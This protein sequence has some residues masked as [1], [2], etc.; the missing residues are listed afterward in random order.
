MKLQVL[1][2]AG[3]IGGHQ[4]F[5]TCLQVDDDIL[6]DAGT[7]ITSLDIDQLVKIDHV[8]ITHAHL[9]HVCGLALLVDAVRGKKEGPVTVHASEQVI[10]ALK[11][12]LFNWILWPDFAAI[13]SVENPVVRWKPF[14]PATAIPVGTRTIRPYPVNHT[15]GSV[16]Y[17]LEQGDAGFLFSGDMGTTPALW[18]RLQEEKKLRAVIVD[19]SFPNAECELAAKSMHFCPQSLLQDITCMPHSIDF[20]IYH[21]KPGQED[22]IMNEL[23][24]VAA[25]RT[26][27]ALKCGD[28]FVF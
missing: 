22:L 8:F 16:A 9:D 25:G 2:C 3:G 21:L 4:R 12:Y 27:K 19:C 18:A 5:T 15:R 7:G 1:G 14:T 23:M 10:D 17:W 6:L 11:Q 20:L 28:V 13:P 26:F 24:T